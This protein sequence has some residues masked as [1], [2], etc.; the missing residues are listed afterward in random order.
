VKDGKV[1]IGPNDFWLADYDLDVHALDNP[2]SVSLTSA[3]TIE[4]TFRNAGSKTITSTTV[5]VEYSVD[6][7]KT[8]VS[9][10]MTITSLDP[11]KTQTYKFSKTWSPSRSGDFRVSIRINPQISGDPDV[12]DRKDWDICSGISGSFTIGS[13]SGADYKTFGDAVADLAC[14]ASGP[15]TFNI[16]PGTYNEQVVLKEVFGASAT[17]TIT[18]DGGDIDSVT[19]QFNSSTNGDNTLTFDGADYFVFKDMRIESDGS[20]GIAVHMYNAANYN[21]ISGCVVQANPSVVSTYS[22]P[23]VLQATQQV[24]RLMVTMVT[25]TCLKTIPL[26]VVTMV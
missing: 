13:S 8:W 15:I 24:Q 5:D 23:L 10:K 25:T 2:L 1:D 18:F 7:G 16:E 20:A 4:A 3:N 21:R 12:T 14:G 11:G 9:E 6:S 26:S 17:N 19:L 22:H